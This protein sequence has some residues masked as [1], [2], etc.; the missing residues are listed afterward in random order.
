MASLSVS[1]LS[2]PRAEANCRN[3]AALIDVGIVTE[4]NTSKVIDKSKIQR[5]DKFNEKCREE[6]GIS[7][8]GGLT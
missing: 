1:I 4:D 7:F 8:M 6:G 5:A 2:S 3:T